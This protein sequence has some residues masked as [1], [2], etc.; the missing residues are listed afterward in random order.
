MQNNN[1]K[2]TIQNPADGQY[3]SQIRAAFRRGLANQ[4]RRTRLTGRVFYALSTRTG[5][6]G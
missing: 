5:I 3:E 1:A 6:R 2:H 4:P